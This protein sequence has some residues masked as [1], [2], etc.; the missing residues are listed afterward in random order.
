MWGVSHFGESPSD[1]YVWGYTNKV[2]LAFGNV[3]SLRRR[4]ANDE[5]GLPETR[6]G[7]FSLYSRDFQSPGISD[8]VGCS[9][10]L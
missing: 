2:R 4:F 9:P 7:G 3:F 8:I 6:A 10:H 1:S 5:R